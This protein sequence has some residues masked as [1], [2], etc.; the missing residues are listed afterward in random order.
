MLE[1][2]IARALPKVPERG[3]ERRRNTEGYRKA[4]RT[5]SL[6]AFL[7]SVWAK[8]IG[9]QGVENHGFLLAK[10]IYGPKKEDH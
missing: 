5:G 6:P 4:S 3:I 8:T 1:Q 10:Y 7:N 2:R 9:I